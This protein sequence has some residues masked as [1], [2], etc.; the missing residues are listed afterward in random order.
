[1]G[2]RGLVLAL[3]VCLS[4]LLVGCSQDKGEQ[5]PNPAQMAALAGQQN[6]GNVLC[7]SDARCAAQC[8][9]QYVATPQLIN[10]CLDSM[11]PKQGKVTAD[12]S[13]IADA[14]LTEICDDHGFCLYFPSETA[15]QQQD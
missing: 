5:Q 2:F 11:V 1:M 3:S 7:R 4:L 13:L 9:K 14:H 6:T 8:S 15:S 12:T 10:S